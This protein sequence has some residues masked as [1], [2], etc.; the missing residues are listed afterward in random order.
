MCAHPHARAGDPRTPQAARARRLGVEHRDARGEAAR[1]EPAGDRR[2]ARRALA[3]IDGVASAE[4]AGPG[5]IN[6]RLDAAAAGR[7]RQGDRRRGACLR[8]QRR[9]RRRRSHQPRV[10]VGEPHGAAA[11]RP[12]AMGGA[13]RLDRPRAP[14]GRCRG[15]ERVL[16][17]RRRHPD[18]QLRPVRAGGRQGRAHPRGRLSRKL[19]RRP[20][21]PG[22][23]ARA[24][25]P[26]ARRGRRAA[27]RHRDR[28]RAPARRDPRLARPLQRALRRLDERTPHA[29]EGRRRPVR[30]R[31]RR[32]APP[33]A[34]PRLRRGR[35][36]VGAHDR[37]R[38][39]QGPGD[40]PQQ[41]RLH[42]LR[43]RRGLLPRQGRSRLRPQDLPPRRRPPRLRA[44]PPRARRGRGR[45]PRA[46]HRGAHR[47]ARQHQRRRSS[48]SAPAT[49]SSSTT[50]RPGSAPMRCVTRS[51]A[52][53][54]TRRSPSTPRS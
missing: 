23:R 16:H 2:R 52:I 32:R 28:L 14:R 48:P 45:R 50:C 24:E 20:R 4:V 1:V 11:H 22:A 42:V 10:R 29:G 37:L 15:G 9:A 43:G 40:P 35:R 34:G 3:G 33:R 13:R 26:R 12:H 21:G 17:Q 30:R 36:R 6:I 5:F 18:G 53:P 54:P 31:H 49:S 25:A 41:R 8:A 44:P 27:R 47:P 19:H 7:A 38:R 51:R 46:R 39:R